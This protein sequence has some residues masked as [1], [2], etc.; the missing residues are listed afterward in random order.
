MVVKCEVKFEQN[1]HGVF[2]SG[3][4]M[5]GSVEITLDKPRTFK[6]HYSIAHPDIFNGASCGGGSLLTAVRILYTF[7]HPKRYPATYYQ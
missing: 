7:L 4:V 5:S 2:Y 3:Q 1:P 6:G